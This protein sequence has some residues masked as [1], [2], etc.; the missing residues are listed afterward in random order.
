MKRVV[1]FTITGLIVILVGAI[2]IS[3]YGLGIS[4]Q[5]KVDV[6]F[7]TSFDFN[8]LEIYNK[9]WSPKVRRIN[10]FMDDNAFNENNLKKLFK[11][12]ADKNPEPKH[13]TIILA[14]N[15]KQIELPYDCPQRLE[16]SLPDDPNRYDY[17]QAIFKRR[18]LG[19]KTVEYFHYYP[20]LKSSEYTEVIM[21][22][23][24]IKKE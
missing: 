12:V 5:K 2:H 23:R 3:I 20:V 16:S 13:L 18:A 22:G 17:R 6:S 15:W 8:F 7:C 11:Y 1:I 14:T 4:E 24:R 9:K 19:D 21:K 10:I